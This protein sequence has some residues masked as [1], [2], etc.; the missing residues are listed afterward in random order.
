MTKLLAEQ[1][2]YYV[3]NGAAE[4]LT[5]ENALLADVGDTVRVYFGVG[6]PSKTSSFDVIGEIFDRAYQLASLT[7]PPLLDVQTISV[8]PG[9][10]T[11][12]DLT[13]DVPGEAYPKAQPIPR[14]PGPLARVSVTRNDLVTAVDT[15][16]AHAGGCRALWGKVQFRNDGPYTP[17]NYPPAGGPPSIR[18]FRAFD[19]RTGR[20]LWSA[21][22]DFNVTAIPITYAGRNGKP[23]VAVTAATNGQGNDES[24][25]VSALP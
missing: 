6:G 13:A 3:F 2:E 5:G 22:F 20:E 1:P 24:L 21:R 8:P 23:Y 18:R 25:H 9:G 11:V 10:A 7:S 12:V 14:K 16:P 19:S 17:W 4:G 15:T